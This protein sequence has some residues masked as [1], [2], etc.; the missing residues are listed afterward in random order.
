MRKLYYNIS[1]LNLDGSVKLSNTYSS[2]R[3]VKSV[4]DFYCSGGYTVKLRYTYSI[5]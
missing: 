2:F 5:Y 1:V 4:I 3:Q